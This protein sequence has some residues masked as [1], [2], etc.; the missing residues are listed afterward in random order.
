MKKAISDGM[1]SIAFPLIGV[2]QL[3]Y[4]PTSVAECFHKAKLSAGKS[5]DVS[6][7]NQPVLTMLHFSFRGC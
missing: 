2:G 3:G 6:I 1:S 4:D 5:I 7:V